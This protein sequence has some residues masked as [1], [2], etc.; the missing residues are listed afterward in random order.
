MC[1]TLLSTKYSK[2]NHYVV[3]EHKDTGYKGKYF[4]FHFINMHFHKHTKHVCEHYFLL[5]LDNF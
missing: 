4:A 3:A 2:Y 5:S 1:S